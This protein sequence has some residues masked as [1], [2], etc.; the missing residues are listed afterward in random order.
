VE[1]LA[2]CACGSVSVSVSGEPVAHSVCHCNNCKK[3]TGSAFGISAY[4]PKQA[5][6]SVK[7]EMNVYAFHNASRNEDQQRHFCS[8]CGTT[9]YWFA[10][11][12]PDVVGIAGGCF[13]DNPLG[14]PT[15]TASHSK[16]LD[17]VAVPSTWRVW[18]E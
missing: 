17:W 5:M 2:K 18:P 6:A 4:F 15:I 13:A 7:G 8:K 11:T 16:K 14:E 10:S 9:V 3:R 12:L 1:R